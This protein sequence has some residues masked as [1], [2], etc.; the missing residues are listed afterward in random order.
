[1][2]AICDAGWNARD[3]NTIHNNSNASSPIRGSN[4]VIGVETD[5]E[6]YPIPEP[7]CFLDAELRQCVVTGAEQ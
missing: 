5:D 7:L 4:T 6:T 3:M 2:T 1:M